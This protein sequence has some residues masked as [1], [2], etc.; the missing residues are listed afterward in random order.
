[1]VPFVSEVHLK[2]KKFIVHITNLSVDVGYQKSLLRF[3]NSSRSVLGGQNAAFYLTHYFQ[4]TTVDFNV[5]CTT[6]YE[7]RIYVDF[8]IAWKR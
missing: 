7:F 5:T 6:L 8:D 3:K 4:S 2:K 1:M